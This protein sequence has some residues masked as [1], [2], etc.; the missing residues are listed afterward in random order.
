MLDVPGSPPRARRAARILV[1]TNLYPTA[2]HPAFGTFVGARVG[3]MRRAGATVAVAA[4]TDPGLHR[5]VARKY[6]RLTLAAAW[7]ALSARLRRRPYDV[8]EAHIAFPTGLVAWP[9]ATLGGARLSLFCHGSDVIRLP[10]LSRRRAF[11][12]RRLFGRADLVLANSHYTAEVASRRLGPLRRP[13]AVVSPGIDLGRG[14]ATG[15]SPVREPDHVLFVG[16]LVP[17]KGA[18][19]LLE[20]FRALLARRPAARVTIVGDG[21]ERA[22]LEQRTR[23]VTGSVDFRG[24]LP[25]GAVADLLRRA[26]VVAVPSTAPEGLS[27]VALEAMAH[28]ALVVATACGGLAE[29]MRH[30]ENGFVVPPGDVDALATTLDEALTAAAGPRGE[31]LRAA[32]RE[33]A[34]SHDLDAVVAAS[35][36]RYA[37]SFA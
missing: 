36:D 6:L 8:V 14:A 32:G 35:L 11:L 18:E 1:V 28:G 7:T 23:D 22:A 2:A 31:R 25:P 19:V 24:A 27:L 16:R 30:G 17:G 33:T 26:S 20:A 13:V 37:E 9:I 29:T 4:I 5:N 3:A 12:A 15:A 10:W 34:A 21:S